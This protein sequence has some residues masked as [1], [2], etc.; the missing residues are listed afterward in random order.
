MTKARGHLAMDDH[1]FE[2]LFQSMGEITASKE[3]KASTLSAIFDEMDAEDAMRGASSGERNGA[4][5]D[6]GEDTVRLHLV[7][8]EPTQVLPHLALVSD[9]EDAAS[10][11][12]SP[13]TSVRMKRNRGLRLRVAAA[14]VAV[15][16]LV[17][18]G[19][20]YAVPAAQVAV[21]VDD[22]TFELG[23]NVFGTTV[24]AKADS[25]AG[26]KAISAA[27]VHNMRF[28]DALDHL[29]DS[30]EKDRD[31]SV[32]TI[33][34]DVSDRFGGRGVELEQ[35]ADRVAQGH[36]A[37]GEPQV[38]VGEAGQPAQDQ[39]PGGEPGGNQPTMDRP[40][41]DAPAQ[42]PPA[43]DWTGWNQ[44][45]Q[46]RPEQ[47]PQDGGAQDQAPQQEPVQEQPAA[48]EPQE[49]RQEQTEPTQ[50]TRD[51]GGQDQMPQQQP[52]QAQP[53]PGATQGGE[54]QPTP[55]FGQPRQGQ[56]TGMADA[57]PGAHEFTSPQEGG[58][59]MR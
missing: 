47:G 59:P 6:T 17:G 37:P 44:P 56:P 45:T 19:V 24:S 22:T 32:G 51:G 30:Y 41:Q 26:R 48:D 9:D 46:A 25:D 29:L 50:D 23:V 7:P 10:S 33:E 39:G 8:E 5:D 52:S 28:E 21:M 54:A 20:A 49:T 12:G 58:A 16:L 42:D 1:D 2:V 11:T 27:G 55:D 13:A 3:L 53:E 18:G 14:V 43:P 40:T 36:L 38:P 31:G 57:Q 15:A 34:I 4:L 35:E